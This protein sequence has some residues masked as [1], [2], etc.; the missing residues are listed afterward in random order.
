[1]TDTLSPPKVNR[2]FL[3][4]DHPMV[5]IG[6]SQIVETQDD[7]EICGEIDSGDGAA[8]AIRAA[9]ADLVL[10]DLSLGTGA[11][12]LV[13]LKELREQGI[14]IPIVV[15][16]MHEERDNAERAL[17]A[18]ANGYIMKSE[19]GPVLLDCV[20]QVLA[21]GKYLS[22]TMTQFIIDRMADKHERKNESSVSSLSQRELEVFK[23]IGLGLP[24]S[25]IAEE[26]GIR[27][28]T[29]DVYR[30]NIKQKLG[31]K[32]GA[33]LAREAVRWVERNNHSLD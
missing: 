16:S 15:V 7:L 22:G 4:D 27:P 21:G 6:M 26:L 5:R 14:S 25:Q 20:R 18:G 29:V 24:S 17:Q 13:V 8:E 30:G 2:L 33:Q 9:Q 3:I 11:S 19:P 23:R 12:G 1:M 10:L 28:S 31:L 32:D